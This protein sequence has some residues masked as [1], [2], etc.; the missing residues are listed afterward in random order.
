MRFRSVRAVTW[1]VPDAAASA[2]AFERWL[3]Y[4]PVWRGEVTPELAAAWNAPASVRAPC[5]VMRPASGEEVYLRFVESPPVP[6]YQPL[7]TFGWNAAELHV[8]DVQ[9]LAAT[10]DGSPFSV[11]GG[12]RDLLENGAVIALQV[13]G[14]GGELLYLTEMRHPGMRETYGYATAVVG[15]V[16]IVVL[17]VSDPP[18]SMDFYRPFAVRTTERRAFP[19]KVLANAHGLDPEQARFDIASVVM[20][21]RFRIETDA[22]PETAR[23]RPALQGRLPPGMC[24][25]SVAVSGDLPAECTPCHAPHSPPYMDENLA[26]LHGPDGEWLELLAPL[27]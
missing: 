25:V 10:L 7:K 22:Y 4:R 24:M 2:A 14:P 12:P 18:R 9:G 19:I 16:F 3:G 26:M 8:Q 5:R 23:P 21:E 27:A 15:R 13:Q 6:G 20:E 11:I 17:G 1:A